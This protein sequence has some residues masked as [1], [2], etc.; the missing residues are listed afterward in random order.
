MV[1]FGFGFGLFCLLVC[2]VFPLLTLF[3]SSLLSSLV[4][5][6]NVTKTFL[7]LLFL[8]LFFIFL[9]HVFFNVLTA[10]TKKIYMST[11]KQTHP[12]KLNSDGGIVICSSGCIPSTLDRHTLVS[13]KNFFPF[14]LVFFKYKKYRLIKQPNPFDDF[15]S[16]V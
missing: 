9:C 12:H 5:T 10:K 11:S 14:F 3:F 13:K 15:I 8:F 16:L 4:L 6:A 7:I 1:W 2:L